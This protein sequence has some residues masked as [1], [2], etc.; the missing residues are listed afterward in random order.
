MK[1]LRILNT[2]LVL[3][4]FINCG[5]SGGTDGSSVGDSESDGTVEE[6]ARLTTM[7]NQ[8]LEL[9]N[10]EREDD[11]LPTLV[12]DTGLDRVMLWYGTDM[13]SY[14]HIGHVDINDRRAE[15]R[16][17]YYTDQDSARCSEITAWWSGSSATDH[18][19]AYKNSEGHHAAYMEEGLYNLGPTTHVGVIALAGTGPEDSSYEG[20]SG[21]YSGL[22]FCDV[23]TEIE[24]DPFEDE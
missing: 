12:R 13:V 7:E 6:A 3:V 23:S 24:I 17:R 15:E 16:V 22:V 1:L 9:I 21:T 5:S 8:I 18:Y 20:S 19:N 11:G 10:D 2:V 14:N 4:I